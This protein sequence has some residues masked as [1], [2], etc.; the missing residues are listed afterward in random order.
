MLITIFAGGEAH[1]R[2]FEN[3]L[4]LDDSLDGGGRILVCANSS[5]KVHLGELFI[6]PCP[7]FRYN[8]QYMGGWPWLPAPTWKAAGQKHSKSLV[9]GFAVSYPKCKRFL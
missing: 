1:P 9:I 7:L 5:M 4:L 8:I 2:A 3:A 6:M